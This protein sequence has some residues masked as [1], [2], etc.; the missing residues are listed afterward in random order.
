MD[1]A[2][3]SHRARMY[4]TVPRLRVTMGLERRKAYRDEYGT[5]PFIRQGTVSW[6]MTLPKT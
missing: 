1:N 3:L 2:V 5:F 4:G 6:T